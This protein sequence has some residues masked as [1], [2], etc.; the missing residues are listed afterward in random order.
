MDRRTSTLLLLALV[1]AGV[2]VRLGI[3]QLARL[4]E[5]RTRNAAVAARFTQPPTTLAALPADTAARHYRRVR[6]AGRPLYDRELRLVNRSR[7]GSPGVNIVTPV[8]V[9][10]ADTLVLV[11]RGWI[12]S[13]N[14]TDLDL[15]RWHEGDSLDVLGYVELPSR[16]P[17]PAGVSGE[18]AYRW[19][20]A[21]TV[22]RAIGAPVTPY[23]VVAE[24]PA[25][26][27][28]TPL[29]RPVRLEPPALDEGSHQSYAI[30]W[31]SFATVA[32]VG[33]AA[34][35]RANR[36]RGAPAADTR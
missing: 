30:Q 31:F 18:R 32:I 25:G 2:C 22:A 12:Y 33:G 19:L 29:D 13:A 14:G 21:D 24:P 15:A 26:E 8:R 9:A 27:T 23:Y 4:D 3:W 6:V 16:R 5:R 10:G 35:A 20:D 36:R 1:V 11:N 34:V 28:K 17:G 7:N